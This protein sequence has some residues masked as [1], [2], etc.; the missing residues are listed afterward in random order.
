MRA[1]AQTQPSS[2]AHRLADSAGALGLSEAQLE[3]LVASLKGGPLHLVE[4]QLKAVLHEAAQI[5]AAQ[6]LAAQAVSAEPPK[7]M[8][9]DQLSADFKAALKTGSPT[10]LEE[11]ATRAETILKQDPSA[12]RA[13][14]VLGIITQS[15]AAFRAAIQQEAGLLDRG[16]FRFSTSDSE[17]YPLPHTGAPFDLFSAASQAK[18][19]GYRPALRQAYQDVALQQWQPSMQ[20]L[21]APMAEALGPFSA[22]RKSYALYSAALLELLQH[23]AHIGNMD[24]HFTMNGPRESFG[25]GVGEIVAALQQASTA[26]PTQ[27]ASGLEKA[28]KLAHQLLR[29]AGRYLHSTSA[30]HFDYAALIDRRRSVFTPN[31]SGVPAEINARLREA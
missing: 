8:S 27:R 12:A 9:Q 22:E 17:H 1:I 18:M 13:A 7:S 15:P 4:G 31:L 2:T 29:D 5:L 14:M 24:F 10:A 3:G 16:V 19:I 26:G 20:T 30:N 23:P 11:L 6:T 25:A 28:E 21:A